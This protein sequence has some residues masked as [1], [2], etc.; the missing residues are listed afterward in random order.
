MTVT[1]TVLDMNS[2]TT[3][4][5][6]P[7]SSANIIPTANQPLVV[8][9]MLTAGSNGAAPNPIVSGCNLT[10]TEIENPG[11][12][13]GLRTIGTWV[14]IGPSPTSGS[15]SIAGNGT[16]TLTSGMWCA[17]QC[18]GVD[19][20]TNNGVAQSISSY[21]NSGTSANVPFTNPINNSNSALAW[22]ELNSVSVPVPG[23]GWTTLGNNNVSTPTSTQEAQYSTPAQQNITATYSTS[24]DIVAGCELTTSTGSN[25]NDIKAGSGNVNLAV[26]GSPASAAYIG[27]TKVYP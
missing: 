15:L 17:V 25:L 4:H 5:T 20:T 16:T 12:G 3:N 19:T 24:F 1:F 13:T 21:G 11:P 10:W 26:G 6:G 8:F 9:A 23:S 22:V 14:G 7:Y 18:A 27:S 2:D